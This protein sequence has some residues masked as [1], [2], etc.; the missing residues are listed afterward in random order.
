MLT[1]SLTRC[2]HEVVVGD[3]RNLFRGVPLGLE[4]FF[5]IADGCRTGSETRSGRRRKGGGGGKAEATKT[6]VE[7]GVGVVAQKQE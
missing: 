7:N 1:K 6:Q 2:N 4:H 3:P 5:A